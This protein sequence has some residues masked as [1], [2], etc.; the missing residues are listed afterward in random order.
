M[1]MESTPRVSVI[2]PAYFSFSTI[3]ASL[4]SL[5]KQSFQ[6]F[7]V[8]VVN[9]SPEDL[10]KRTVQ[11]CYPEALFVQ[12]PVRLLPHAARNS[13]VEHAQGEL[14]VFT[15]PDCEADPEWLKNLVAVFDSGKEALTGAMGFAGSGWLET[16]IHLCKFHWLLPGLESEGKQCAPTANAAFSRRL[17]QKI[18]PFPGDIYAGDGVVSW[19]ALQ[20]GHLPFFVPEAVTRH[21]HKESL[22]ELCRQ[23]FLRG[24]DYAYAQITV[25]GKSTALDWLRLTFSWSAAGLVLLRAGRAAF[26]VG[27]GREFLLTLPVQFLGHCLWALGESCGALLLLFGIPAKEFKEE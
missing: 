1:K 19:R 5:K 12:S 25:M 11:E 3:A 6:N 17:W 27:W 26:R 24:R 2:I 16:G 18:G 9:S 14:L 22:K 10:T 15:D 21:H 8:I 20:Q 4:T 7:E 23:R 13:G